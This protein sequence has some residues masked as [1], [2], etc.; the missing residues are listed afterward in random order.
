[1]QSEAGVE[2]Y[3]QEIVTRVPN[4]PTVD[5]HT[6]LRLDIVNY[7]RFNV[8]GEVGFII[9]EHVVIIS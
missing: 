4:N 9:K 7:L 6:E 1:M 8:D 5:F 2:E 3:R